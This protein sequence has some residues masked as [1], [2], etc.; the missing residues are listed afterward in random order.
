MKIKFEFE[1]DEF[2]SENLFS[3]LCDYR[4]DNYLKSKDT[5]IDE[6]KRAWYLAHSK[7]IQSIM[8]KI[9]AGQTVLDETKKNYEDA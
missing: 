2:E 7:Y 4:T 3:I 9:I 5:D 8:D 6:H 1:F